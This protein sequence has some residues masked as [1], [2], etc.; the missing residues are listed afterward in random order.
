MATE[1]IDRPMTADEYVERAE[2]APTDVTWEL[3]DGQLKE[4][5]M[6]TR[7][8]EHCEAIART[9]YV[10]TAWLDSAAVR[11]GIIAAGE[12]RCR[13][14]ID[15]DTIVGIDVAFFRGQEFVNRPEGVKFY[16]GPPVL[17]VEVLSPSD[18]HGNINQRI[19]QFLAAGVAQ[20]WVANPEFQTITVHRSDADPVMYA[21]RQEI[22]GGGDL[23][24]FRARVATLF[25]G[26]R[27]S[28]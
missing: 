21:S 24:G 17:A 25:T 4:R 18:E 22:E 7:G 5:P 2:S 23:P 26:A 11:D 20:V 28:Q 12:A 3:I 27:R 6:T 1:T 9:A 15:P 8:P 13:I 19:R 14:S 10:L 16:D